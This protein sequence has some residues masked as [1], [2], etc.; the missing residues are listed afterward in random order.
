MIRLSQRGWNNVI[1]FTTLIL[2]L[3]FNFSSDFLNRGISGSQTVT[4][5]LPQY[6]V[7]TTIEYVHDRVERIGQGW[8]TESGTLSNQALSQLV[9]NWHSAEVELFDSQL[10]WQ[11]SPQIIK[12]WFV[13]Q[14]QPV[15]YYFLPFADKTLVKFEQQTYLL[16]SPDFSLLNIES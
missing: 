7:I 16:L 14:A 15:E 2:I 8:R 5:L 10:N 9:D 4:R 6:A 3:L 12:V 1:I 13:G 11:T